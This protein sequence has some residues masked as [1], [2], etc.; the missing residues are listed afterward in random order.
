MSMSSPSSRRPALIGGGLLV[1]AGIVLL[2]VQ[3]T[4]LDLGWPAGIVVVGFGLI[5]VGVLVGPGGQAFAV[6]G[7]IIGMVGIVLAAQEA[8][9]AY[10]SWAYAWALVAPFGVGLGMFLFGLFTGA[11]PIMRAGIGPMVVGLVI[12]L[13]GYVFFE[14]MIGLSGEPFQGSLAPALLIGLGVLL[15]IGAFLAPRW[16]GSSP[17]GWPAGSGATGAG[18]G[19]PETGAAG[20]AGAAGATSGSGPAAG[21][22]APGAA[23]AGA[24]GVASGDAGRTDGGPV[25]IDLRD[26][27]VGDVAISFGAG[28]LAIGGVAAP[29]HLVDGVAYG[30][31]VVEDLGPG[32]VKLSPPA[33]AVFTRLWTTPPFDWRLRLTGEVPMRLVADLGASRS[34]LDLSAL[35]IS[36]LRLRTGAAETLVTLPAGAGHTRV[37]IEGGANTVDLRIPD[38]VAARIHSAMALGSTRVDERRFPRDPL[39]GWSSPDFGTAANRVEIESRGGVG[40]LRV[41]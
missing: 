7:G 13:V 39:G 10:A 21:W 22:T 28:T 38:G 26:A 35:L 3:Q 2:V 8:L 24:A 41:S 34:S 9:D 29:S 23:A 19:A 5:A 32:R 15:V 16:R 40:S 25:A 20:G 1:A 4:G 33:D 31:F 12:F 14:G 18:P 6:L 27:S 17:T 37:D 11:P 30:G 36:E